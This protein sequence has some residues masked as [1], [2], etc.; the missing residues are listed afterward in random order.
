[1]EVREDFYPG[2]LLDYY[3]ISLIG[4]RDVPLF[5][6]TSFEFSHNTLIVRSRTG[7]YKNLNE[8]ENLDLICALNLIINLVT[9]MMQCYNYYIFPEMYVVDASAVY[10]NH[11][12]TRVK[13]RFIPQVTKEKVTYKDVLKKIEERMVQLVEEEDVPYLKRAIDLIGKNHIGTQYALSQI[14]LLVK[15]HAL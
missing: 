11:N 10:L 3:Q 15:E 9:G 1:M 8:I 12:C 14:K 6:S 2:D 13:C 7:N 4:T 5:F